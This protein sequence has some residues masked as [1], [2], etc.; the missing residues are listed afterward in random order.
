MKTVYTNLSEIN[1]LQT[2]IMRFV[3]NWARVEKTPIPLRE[4]INGMTMQ[5]IHDFTTIKA[6]KVLLNKG[7]IRRAIVISNKSS[8]VQLRGV[9]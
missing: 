6:I 5:G 2:A 9:L 7:Y 4:I 3:D 8:F 1:D